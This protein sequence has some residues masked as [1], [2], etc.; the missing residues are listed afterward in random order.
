MKTKLFNLGEQFTA[1]NWFEYGRQVRSR[2]YNQPRNQPINTSIN[3]GKPIA[4]KVKTLSLSSLKSLE[5]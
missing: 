5:R 3:D 1:R 4:Q 2:S